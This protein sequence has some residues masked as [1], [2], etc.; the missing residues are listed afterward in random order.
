MSNVSREVT[1]EAAA[2]SSVLSQ[3]QITVLLVDDQPM[4]GEAVRRMLA[5][6]PDI[7]FKYCQDPTQAI[8]MAQE[9]KPTVILQ[10]L[11]MPQMDG[12]TLVKFFR[13]NP[14]TRLVPM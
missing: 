14:E 11:V 6:Q 12:L 13:A 4:I 1:F 7:A 9:L 10:D 5:T 2:A 8:K 3:H